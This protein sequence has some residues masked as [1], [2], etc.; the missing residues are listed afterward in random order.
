MDTPTTTAARIAAEEGRITRL[1]RLIAEAATQARDGHTV[2]WV[3]PH[4]HLL[5]D[6][7]DALTRAIGDD[8]LAHITRANGR[9]EL[10]TKAGG[11]ILI[12]PA[13]LQNRRLRGL[14]HDITVYY[15]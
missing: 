15:G 14:T 9:E 11:R 4:L 10:R 3:A 8:Q 7:L 5:R 2:A 6:R 12:V 13:A 1:D